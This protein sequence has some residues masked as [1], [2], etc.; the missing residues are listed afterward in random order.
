MSNPPRPPIVPGSRRD[1]LARDPVFGTY[2]LNLREAHHLYTVDD[3]KQ[4]MKGHHSQVCRSCRTTWPCEVGLALKVI[5]Y[6]LQV[7]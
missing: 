2:Y 3:G 1:L 5:D 4:W 7:G 6:L